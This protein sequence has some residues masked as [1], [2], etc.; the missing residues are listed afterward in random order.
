M[1]INAIRL[2]NVRMVG[3][4]GLA[5]ED[6][7]DGLSMLA[8]PNERGKTTI[9]ESLRTVLF[10][11]HKARN[12]NVKKILRE[13]G[14]AA[15]IE[16]DFTEDNK[17]YRLTKQY[18]KGERAKLVD[19]ESGTALF[20]G[21][22]VHDWLIDRI[23]ASKPGEGPT[24]LLWVEQGESMKTPDAGESGKS[25]LASLLERQIGDITGGERARKL[26]ARTQ[27]ELSLMVT[28]TGK[29]RTN[30][31]YKR[32]I[33]E[34][35]RI[36]EQLRKAEELISNSEELLS[37]LDRLENSIEKLQDPAQ[38]REIEA[39]IEEA[40]SEREKARAAHQVIE[41]LKDSLQDKSEA[42][43]R[44]EDELEEF[45]QHRLEV[46][47]LGATLSQ[48][49]TE[50]IRLVAELEPLEETIRELKNKELEAEAKQKE[51][52]L[53]AKQ[54][55]EAAKLKADEEQLAQAE[56]QLEKANAIAGELEGLKTKLSANQAT[57]ETLENIKESIKQLEVARARLESL[58]TLLMP[59][60]TVEGEA[61]VKLDDLPLT[62]NVYLS[63]RQVLSL[64]NLGQIIFEANDPDDARQEFEAAETKLSEQLEAIGANDF[65]A[66]ERAGLERREI[67][68]NFERRQYQLEQL[69]PDGLASLQAERDELAANVAA[70]G[71]DSSNE[72]LPDVQTA[73]NELE[74]ARDRFDSLRSQKSDKEENRQSLKD[75]IAELDADM[76]KIKARRDVLLEK[77]GSQDQW[78][79]KEKALTEKHKQA[80]QDELKHQNDIEQKEKET[81][82]LE[83]AE[84]NLQRLEDS[85]SEIT[86]DLAKKRERR[87]DI[88]G[89]LKSISDGGP[90]E[91]RNNLQERLEACENR[92]NAYERRIK[93]LT[94]IQNE[95]EEAQSNL[96]QTFL[97]PVA[98]ELS[99]LLRVVIPG[100]DVSLGD[101]FTAEKVKRLGRV[102]TL[103]SLSGGTKE[104]IAVLTRLAF[105][106][107]MA[108]RGRE[109]PV[110]LDD[111]LVWCDDERLEKVFTALRMAANDIQCIVLTCHESAFRRLGAPSL[112][113]QTWPLRD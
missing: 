80:Q 93:I 107:L 37:E 40:R 25:L 8:A 35:D 36:S 1:R 83:A 15:V 60:L 68:K 27:D 112:E 6:I 29:P 110:V 87:A 12:Q 108:N 94:L 53:I 105:A 113:L 22:E 55:R 95:L 20:H 43:Q 111:A 44:A 69:T 3:S 45:R 52:S 91:L 75:K 38:I 21:D 32:E 81:T 14:M 89:Q 41:A 11:K 2:R 10:E 101:D 98:N 51:A 59:E 33:D 28:K 34:R 49:Q 67:E 19:L 24:G 64:D 78:E 63:G 42:T 7:P 82:S 57:E 100:A 86:H 31:D 61:K 79:Q 5:I 103:A 76:Q 99:P 84:H 58:R 102:E 85:K 54:S 65:A 46:N 72:A 62:E 70:A 66:A 56:Q 106:K 17:S 97:K 13:P 39:D 92:V 23:G 47:D 109:M 73:E 16:L 77:L 104:Q 71:Q 4:K 26:L 96:T 9:F 48:I 50:R 88:Q 90:Q 74:L 18:I 30:T